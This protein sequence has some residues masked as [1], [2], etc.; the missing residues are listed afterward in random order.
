M[1]SE[2][3]ERTV[4][5]DKKGHLT[6][7]G[8]AKTPLWRYR[9][10]SVKRRWRLKEINYYNLISPLY[11][12]SIAISFNRIGL[13][14]LYT[15]EVFDFEN[16][17]FVK[18][19]FRGRRALHI[20]HHQEFNVAWANTSLRIAISRRGDTTHLLL[21][22]PN[23]NIK[24]RGVGI[25]GD[26]TLK[27][28]EE[29]ESLNVAIPLDENRSHFSLSETALPLLVEGNLSIGDSKIFVKESEMLALRYWERRKPIIGQKGLSAFSSTLLKGVPFGF[30]LCTLSGRSG[31]FY[32]GKIYPLDKVV[33]NQTKKEWNIS[34]P[35]SSLLVTF[36]PYNQGET[37][38][39]SF[40]GSTLLNNNNKI[41]FST[42]LGVVRKF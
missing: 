36:T 39:G 10:E 31:I 13:Y 3:T 25:I 35:K 16:R 30:Y 33:F 38:Y 4:L 17:A 28:R 1:L 34:D 29:D 21:G 40:S 14:G 9:R 20:D 5:L 24:K 42:L 8:W 12:L 15:I 23:L 18:K 32:D 2:V 22:A 19:Q 11:N 26:F 27:S 41:E 6:Q 37:L 7:P